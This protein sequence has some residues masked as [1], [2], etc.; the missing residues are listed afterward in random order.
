[1]IAG[2]KTRQRGVMTFE[3]KVT[4]A[5]IHKIGVKAVAAFLKRGGHTVLTINLHPRSNPQ[6]VARIDRTLAF[7]IVRTATY[8]RKGRL[9]TEAIIRRLVA[10]ASAHKAFCYFA[11]LGIASMEDGFKGNSDQTDYF[12]DGMVV[13]VEGTDYFISFSGLELLTS[14][15]DRCW[16]N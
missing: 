9:F 7:I 2:I 14:P 11:S 3:E 12:P 13:Q 8:P 16:Q 4:P 6:I 1:M 10:H 15:G 5:N